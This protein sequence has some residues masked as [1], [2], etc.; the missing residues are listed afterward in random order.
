MIAYDKVLNSHERLQVATYLALK[1]GITLTEPG[2]T[3]LNSAGEVIWDG[4]KYS[5]WHHNIAGICRDDSAVLDQTTA[6]SS[7]LPGL[8]TMAARDTL[9]N[10][11]FL[12]WGDNGKP[13]TPAAKAPGMPLLLQKTWLMKPH[14]NLHPFATN[15]VFDTKS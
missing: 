13:L 6:C 14:G 9:A 12:L 2:A 11:S 4:Y 15:L 5:A 7:N 1:Y 10:N 8:L 3:Y